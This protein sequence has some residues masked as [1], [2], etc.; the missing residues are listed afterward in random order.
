MFRKEQ[1]EVQNFF[2]HHFS[3]NFAEKMNQQYIEQLKGEK[4]DTV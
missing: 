1:S 2:F 4:G 3:L